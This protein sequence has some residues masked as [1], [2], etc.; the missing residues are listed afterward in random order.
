M[1]A[2]APS[3]VREELVACR[4]K[5]VLELLGRL[6]ALYAPGGAAERESAL[7]NLQSPAAANSIQECLDGLRKW[8]RWLHRIEGIGGSIPDASLLLKGLKTLSKPLVRAE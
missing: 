7:K 3:D 2:A 6:F 4:A 1:I 5:G 8:K